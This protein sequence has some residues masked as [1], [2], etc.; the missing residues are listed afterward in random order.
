MT[1][2]RPQEA[3]KRPLLTKSDG[4]AVRERHFVVFASSAGHFRVRMAFKS[5][6][7]AASPTS[8]RQISV[9]HARDNPARDGD[10]EKIRAG[11][12]V[13]PGL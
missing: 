3:G 1:R 10:G 5:F 11:N 6:P 9:R 12:P 2:E 7:P 4:F 8:G 13:P